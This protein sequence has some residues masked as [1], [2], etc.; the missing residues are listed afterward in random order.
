MLLSE[1]LNKKIKY[2]VV[3]DSNSFEAIADIGERR[4]VFGFDRID[5]NTWECAFGERKKSKSP[6]D[7]DGYAS[8]NFDATGSGNEL[9]VF[10]MI[11]E[12]LIEFIKVYEPDLILFSAKKKDNGDSTRG[13][14]YAG[15]LKRFKLTGYEIDRDTSDRQDEFAIRK[16][17]YVAE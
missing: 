11:K 2:D 3:K 5:T 8:M 4:I 6:F 7:R 10:S 9:M 12:A 1:L 14:V 13:N 17:G 16:I 15:L